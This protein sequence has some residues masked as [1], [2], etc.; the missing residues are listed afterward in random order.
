MATIPFDEIVPGATVRCTAIDSLQYLSVRDVLMHLCGSS[1]KTANK[2]WER[3]SGEAKEEVETFCRSFQFPGQGNRPETVITF[4]GALKLAMLV[5]GEK[6]AMHRSAMVNILSRYYAGD[7]SL[8]AEIE[9]NAVSISPITQLARNTLAGEG[10]VGMK[11]PRTD[12]FALE[13][14]AI[15]KSLE[16]GISGQ[17]QTIAAGQEGVAALCTQVDAKQDNIYQKLYELTNELKAERS[18]NESITKSLGDLSAE[19]KKE[20]DRNEMIHKEYTAELKARQNQIERQTAAISHLNTTIRA[21]DAQLAKAD[22]A[23]HS[24]HVKLDALLARGVN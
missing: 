8:S 12:S 14:S 5:S 6:A 11:R 13:I 1:A 3:L 2:K 10:E 19:L 9:A 23:H 7:D 16:S 24:I 20:K 21:K 4:K 17:L 22:S 18:R 15:L